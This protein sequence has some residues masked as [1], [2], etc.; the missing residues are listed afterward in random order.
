MRTF[1]KLNTLL[2]ISGLILA[3]EIVYA[4]TTYS[5]P[6]G[7]SVLQVNEW[8]ACK[9]VTNN[10][11]LP[12]FVPTGSSAEWYSLIDNG[13]PSVSLSNCSGTNLCSIADC[14]NVDGWAQDLDVPNTPVDVEIYRDGPVGTGTLVGR[15]TADQPYTG[16]ANHGFNFTIPGSLRTG[17]SIS[18]YIYSIGKNSSGSDDGDNAYIGT[19]IIRCI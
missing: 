17:N 9:N 2:I 15:V 1:L 8:S 10:N 5:V 12:L 14:A 4:A 7:G 16:Y 11:G 6:G 3:A 19:K 13:A 18:L